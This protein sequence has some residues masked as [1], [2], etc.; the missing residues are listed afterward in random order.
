MPWPQYSLAENQRSTGALIDAL[1]ALFGGQPQAF[2]LDGLA[3]QP[4]REGEKPKPAAA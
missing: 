3:Y 2:M 1:N 4:V